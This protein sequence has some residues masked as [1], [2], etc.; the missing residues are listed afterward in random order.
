[1]KN[2]SSFNNDYTL[3][4]VPIENAR[5]LSLEKTIGNVFKVEDAESIKSGDNIRTIYSVRTLNSQG[6]P[7]GTLINIIVKGQES[8]FDKQMALDTLTGVKAYIIRFDNIN[9][10][11]MA[12]KSGLREGL[13]AEKAEIIN[14]PID[15]V[16]KNE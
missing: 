7:T 6:M 12:T 9:H 2:I 5:R 14:I 13:N 10:W 4:N 15:K 3:A 16:I 8:V 11:I 1:M